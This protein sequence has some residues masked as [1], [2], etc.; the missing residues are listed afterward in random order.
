MFHLGDLKN[1]ET[2]HET[3]QKS[4]IVVGGDTWFL[5]TADELTDPCFTRTHT[6]KRGEWNIFS[7]NDKYGILWGYYDST[8]I[9]TKM[10]LKRTTKDSTGS[11]CI[12]HQDVI[13][14]FREKVKDVVDEDGEEALEEDFRVEYFMDT[15]EAY[16]EVSSTLPN[17]SWELYTAID[18]KLKKVIA[19]ALVEKEN[20][21]W[22]KKLSKS[23]SNK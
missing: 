2:H 15:H 4:M 3:H 13:N 23:I 21:S 11:A 14:E 16:I 22:I 10:K 20:L 6:L 18:R 1:L 8:D 7:F 19:F 5:S 9:N 12:F 17:T